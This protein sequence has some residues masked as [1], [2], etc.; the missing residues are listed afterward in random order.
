LEKRKYPVAKERDLTD[1]EKDIIRQKAD[2]DTYLLAKD[3]RCSPSQ[4]AGVKAAMNR[5]GAAAAR[6]RS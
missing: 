5:S 2:W 3:L 4:V 1:E 6:P